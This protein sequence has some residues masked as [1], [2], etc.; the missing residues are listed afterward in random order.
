[1]P[2]ILAILLSL[3]LEILILRRVIR[4]AKQSHAEEAHQ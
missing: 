3:F 1:M 2:I 4:A